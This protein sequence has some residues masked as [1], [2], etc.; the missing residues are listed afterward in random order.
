MNSIEFVS[1]AMIMIATWYEWVSEYT[2]TDARERASMKRKN[3]QK[4][5]LLLRKIR[6]RNYTRTYTIN[7]S[8]SFLTPTS[9]PRP[10]EPYHDT[11]REV[12]SLLFRIKSVADS[13]LR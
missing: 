7:R 1:D 5:K 3:L 13:H 9:L 6:A 11:V 4:L 8:F 10:L 12:E 2:D